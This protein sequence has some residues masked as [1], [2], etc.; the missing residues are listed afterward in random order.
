MSGRRGH[1][2]GAL[3]ALSVSVFVP[4]PSLGADNASLS[5]VA[6]S[7]LDMAVSQGTFQG[8]SVGLSFSDGTTWAGS[9]GYSDIAKTTALSPTD[10]FR[11]GSFSKTLT[12]TAVL[13][14][15]DQ[16]VIRLTDTVNTWLPS[17]NLVNGD[18]ITISDLL[19]M[20][21]GVPEY[22]S[23]P[24]LHV[25]G[26]TILS[27][28]LN[29]SST[30]GPY[31]YASYT[32]TELIQQAQTLAAGPVGTMS[33]S[34]TNFA[35]LALIAE[36]ASCST[37]SGCQTIETMVNS[38]TAGLGLSS[39]TFPT[40]S[41]FTGPYA[42]NGMLSNGVTYDMTGSNPMV[43]WAAGAVI[44]TPAQ[45]AA[46]S[47]ELATNASGTLSSATFAARMANATVGTVGYLKALYG[48]AMYAMPSPGTGGWVYGHSG[49]IAGY[50]STIFFDPAI[51]IAI[52]V[53]YTGSGSAG[54]ASWYPLYGFEAAY[55]S[56][57]RAGYFNSLPI[58]W[59]ID[60]NLTVATNAAGSCNWNS[61][62]GF[63][64]G[65]SGSC[66]GTNARLTSI[67]LDRAALTVNPSG[68]S[69]GNYVVSGDWYALVQTASP[70]IS[71]FGSALD[72]IKMTGGSTLSVPQGAIIEMTGVGSAAVAS[73]GDSNR[74][75]IA[76]TILAYGNNTVA[77]RGGSGAETV[78]VAS[79][80][81]ILGDVSLGSGADR[82]SVDG[83]VT[84]DVP[85]GSA[86]RLQG[87]GSIV[88]TVTG[89]TVAPGN[90]IG[91]LT[92][93][94]YTAADSTLEIEVGANG[95]DLL[96]ATGAVNLTGGRLEVVTSR[97]VPD[98]RSTI[99][100]A[101]TLTGS[102]ASVSTTGR[103]A[104]ATRTSGSVI[105]LATVSPTTL[106]GG[107]LIARR[108]M[109]RAANAVERR[110]SSST[111]VSASDARLAALGFSDTASTLGVGSAETSLVDALAAAPI[112]QTLS[113]GLRVWTD[114]GRA[115]GH[116]AA[117]SDVSALDLTGYDVTVG[118]EMPVGRGFKVGALFSH[119]SAK[120]SS[121][122]TSS[123]AVS[124]MG[125]FYAALDLDDVVLTG[126]IAGGRGNTRTSRVVE[127][128][129]TSLTAT[130]DQP[131]TR[132]AARLSA[133]RAFDLGGVV[134]EPRAA[135]SYSSLF[136]ETATE[137]GA[138]DA[139]LRYSSHV[140]TALRAEAT[141][142]LRGDLPVADWGF[143]TKLNAE[144][145]AGA[146]RDFAI[147]SRSTEVTMTGFDTPIRLR[148]AE[149]SVVS[150]PVGA[151]IGADLGGGLEAVVS[152]DGE[153][154]TTTVEHRLGLSLR[155]T[156]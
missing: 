28:W 11:V 54:A 78:N 127:S 30:T 44:G 88:G 35:L 105:T 72:G 38:L 123:R 51:N 124:F 104:A 86:A 10:E 95:S 116:V 19:S 34:N 62:T 76:G 45:L 109:A 52:A 100:T 61:V 97:S 75:D 138:G 48:L 26:A 12:G 147:G 27:E 85:L 83:T 129:G 32:P 23:A 152:Y 16:G 126:Q 118:A 65:Q 110:A 112:D 108:G 71:F 82:L 148:S 102:F 91:T 130:A 74:I 94:N 113:S 2:G 81:S 43:P 60:R 21:A 55:G 80:A 33:Y 99:V 114:V 13:Q 47:R 146:A 135:L 143:E 4:T 153:V 22:L 42:Q 117:T 41:A 37:A 156:L 64:P 67:T 77:V 31:G 15:V 136:A 8:A 25:E 128:G 122:F 140:S 36:R 131:D 115:S 14:L 68:L 84:G 90:G 93:K 58:Y 63:G 57:I 79:T 154:S 125:G 50:T 141:A 144:I 53:T 87:T 149:R 96:A 107:A 111:P 3:A 39:I 145:H 56:E 139:D 18:T 101:G 24:S 98:T 132:I 121:D 5:A 103:S 40:T 69:I 29:F 70:S 155:L 1:L 20:T 106:D 151:R 6:Q 133:A 92:V 120:A 9:G 17:L 134:L 150:F 7:V 73:T 66:S 89:G 142:T 119:Q 59:A 49:E 137:S 46:W